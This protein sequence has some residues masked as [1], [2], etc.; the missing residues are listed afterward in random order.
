IDSARS[1][2]LD[3]DKTKTAIENETTPKAQPVEKVSQLI[4]SHDSTAIKITPIFSFEEE[5][6]GRQ[7]DVASRN[8]Q[9][10]YFRR[11]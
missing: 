3:K 5:K 7:P 4:D 10:G 1:K 9:L 2:D 8:Q 11:Y 6:Q